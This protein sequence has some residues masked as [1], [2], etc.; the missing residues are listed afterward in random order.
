MVQHNYLKNDVEFQVQMKDWD[1]RIIPSD[2]PPSC[3]DNVP[4]LTDFRFGNLPLGNFL[5]LAIFSFKR[6]YDMKCICIRCLQ[7]VPRSPKKLLLQR[8][9]PSKSVLSQESQAVCWSHVAKGPSPQG[10]SPCSVVKLS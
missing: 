3:W 9:Y 8:K 7:P 5:F 1:I 4:S 2:L 6:N 10:E